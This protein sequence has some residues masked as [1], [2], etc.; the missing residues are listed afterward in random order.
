MKELKYVDGTSLAKYLAIVQLIFSIITL[1]ITA[2]MGTPQYEV[3]VHPIAAFIGG[4]IAAGIYNFI[5][6]RWGGIKFQIDEST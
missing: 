1:V 2:V 3:I 6:K 4:L 5:A